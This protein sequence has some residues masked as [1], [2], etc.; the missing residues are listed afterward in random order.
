MEMLI[1]LMIW[2]LS[3]IIALALTWWRKHDPT[4]GLRWMDV[5]VILGGGCAGGLLVAIIIL[6]FEI[7]DAVHRFMLKDRIAAFL[8]KRIW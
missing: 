4:L 8:N 1:F 3:G 7:G 6:S 2:C 5:L